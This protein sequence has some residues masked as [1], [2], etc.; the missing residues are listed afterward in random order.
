MDLLVFKSELE[1]YKA[2][3]RHDYIRPQYKGSSGPRA[4]PRISAPPVTK[5][6]RPD[7]PPS[8]L[9]LTA[10]GSI[11][12]WG[13]LGQ[14]LECKLDP[15]QQKAFFEALNEVTI[16]DGCRRYISDFHL[17]SHRKLVLFRNMST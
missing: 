16:G 7:G 4:T 3:R 5:Q 10:V 1:Q 9:G 14:S 6:A 12:F 13:L 11:D 15:L 2:V 8:D 17:Y